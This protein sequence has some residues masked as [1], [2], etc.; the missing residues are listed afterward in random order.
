MCKAELLYFGH[1]QQGPGIVNAEFG[2]LN[3][4]WPQ[5]LKETKHKEWHNIDYNS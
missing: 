5:I 2:V 4:K 1:L 3:F